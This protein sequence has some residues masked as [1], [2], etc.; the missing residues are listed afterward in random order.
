[1]A[2]NHEPLMKLALQEATRARD[3][4]N[5]G[6]GA[7]LVEEGKVIAHGRALM[8][9]TSDL[10]A[11]AETMAL[12]TASAATGRT[13]FANCTLYSTSEPCPMCLA[14]MLVSGV[15]TLVIGADRARSDRRWGAYTPEKLIDLTNHADR[16]EVVRGVLN[17]AC[18]DI[19][20]SA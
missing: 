13:E 11:H 15:S 4:G 8:A 3:E 16:L 20:D 19:R 6:Y 12:R 14:A 18:A 9:T 1:M 17:S 5:P 7:V 10:T 2:E